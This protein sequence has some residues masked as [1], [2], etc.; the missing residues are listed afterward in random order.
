MGYL[1]RIRIF[2]IKYLSF[3]KDKRYLESNRCLQ[4]LTI[5]FTQLQ[6]YHLSRCYAFRINILGGI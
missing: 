5:I 2:T 1:K 3:V 6:Y 4:I